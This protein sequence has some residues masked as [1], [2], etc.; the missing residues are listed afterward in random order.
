MY[1]SELRTYS[2]GAVVAV[3]LGAGGGFG[4]HYFAD[5]AGPA[6]QLR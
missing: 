4:W 5:S 3:L 2:L 1:T 6:P